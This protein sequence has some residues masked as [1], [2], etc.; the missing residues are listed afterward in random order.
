MGEG[1]SVRAAL[2]FHRPVITTVAGAFVTHDAARPYRTDPFFVLY[3]S[4]CTLRQSR[5]ISG[6][7][8]QAEG[9]YVSHGGRGDSSDYCRLGHIA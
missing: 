7:V 1:R 4:V 9:F 6:S 2:Y 8:G 5:P 3:W